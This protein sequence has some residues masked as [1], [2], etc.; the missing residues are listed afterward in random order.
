VRPITP[1]APVAPT[2]PLFGPTHAPEEFTIAVLP[3]VRPFLTM[4]F[5]LVAI[6]FLFIIVVL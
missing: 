3:T 2:K 6:Y 5:E 4:K 1:V